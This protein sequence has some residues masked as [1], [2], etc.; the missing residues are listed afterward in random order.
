MATERLP[1]TR[2]R[3][4]KD[5][6]III[7]N[8]PHLAPEAGKH[9]GFDPGFE[10]FHDTW[11]KLRVFGLVDYERII[12]LDSDMIFLRPMD[13]LFEMELP[14]KDWIAA[15][16]ASICNPF[17]VKNYP[18]DWYVDGPST[19][20]RFPTD[21]LKNR[22]PA[23][24]TIS[25][26]DRFAT[27]HSPPIPSSDGPRTEHLLNSGLV[28]LQPS[29]EQMD[30]IVHVLNTSPAVQGFRF[31][32]QELIAHVY[33]NRWRPLPWWCNAFQ[34]ARAVHQDIWADV[35]VRLIHY[36]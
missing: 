19:W 12:L 21:G 29:R 35:D 5:A 6:G 31:P 24:C 33:R 4:V 25:R 16:P 20:R 1:K 30:H 32:D 2:R 22:T 8:V 36:T 10:R 15:V 14:E 34:T 17:K 23:N 7:I 9:P 28:I 13:E 11:T 3:I 27:L 18:K 26:Q